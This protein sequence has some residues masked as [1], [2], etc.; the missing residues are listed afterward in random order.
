LKV[1]GGYEYNKKLENKDE[2]KKKELLLFANPTIRHMNPSI[3]QLNIIL[4]DKSK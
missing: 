3:K 4:L 2:K 1:E